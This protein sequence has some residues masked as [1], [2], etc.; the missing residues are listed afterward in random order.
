LKR[1]SK[2]GGPRWRRLSSKPAVVW[3]DA[4]VRAL[5][6]GI[7]HRKWALPIA[8]DGRAAQVTGDVWREP[9][10]SLW[11]WVGL[12]LSFIGITVALLIAR[13]PTLI[14]TAAIGLGAFAGVMMVA[15][16]AGFALDANAAAPTYVEGGNEIV[17]AVVGFAFLCRGS[18]DARAMAGGALG[19]LALA[20]GLTKLPTL[21]NGIVLSALPGAA[22]RA[23]VVL[24]LSAGAA[25]TVFG[26]VVFYDVLEGDQEPPVQRS[27]A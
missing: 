20:V 14:R 11:P 16:I 18:L 6:A 3:H 2:T 15:S 1:V 26:L 17:L 4:R 27:A 25:A 9:A 22:A 13:R 5:P 24:M 8:I 7:E 10:P 23:G 12:G 19:L 21:L